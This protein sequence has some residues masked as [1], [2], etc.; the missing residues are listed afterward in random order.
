MYSCRKGI[1]V[2]ETIAEPYST[3]LSDIPVIELGDTEMVDSN[4]PTKSVWK[5]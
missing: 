4:L 1:S 5:I 3:P 2:V